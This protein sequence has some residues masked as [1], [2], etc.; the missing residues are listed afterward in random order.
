TEAE[1]H[2]PTKKK[3]TLEAAKGGWTRGFRAFFHP[4]RFS[5]LSLLM[6]SF[7]TS[8]NQADVLIITEIYPAGEKPIPGVSGKVLYEEIEQLGHKNVVFE[9]DMKKIP[10]AVGKAAQRGDIILVLG[11]GNINQVIPDCIKILEAKG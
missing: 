10:S 8:F 5:R 11:A 9:P 4:P 7:A 3:A 2:P 6:K 1:P